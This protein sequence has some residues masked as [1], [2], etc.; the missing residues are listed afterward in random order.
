MS[1]RLLAIGSPGGLF[2]A[3]LD[4]LRPREYRAVSL[5]SCLFTDGKPVFPG[6]LA[7]AL[8]C[9]ANMPDET[10]ESLPDQTDD[11][12]EI[13]H[14]RIDAILLRTANGI[15]FHCFRE[16]GELD[17]Y[18]PALSDFLRKI[19]IRCIIGS[20]KETIFL[21]SLLI[22]KPYQTVDYRL[23]LLA[24]L[25]DP[26]LETLPEVLRFARSRGIDAEALLPLQEGYEKEEVLPP[27]DAFDRKACQEGLIRTLEKQYVN[28]IGD[29]DKPVAKAGT[30][31]RGYLWDQLGGVYTVPEWRQRG[32]AT[33]L[34]AKTSREL[35]AEGRK[36]VLFVKTRNL[37]ACRAYEKVGFKPDILFRI[38]YF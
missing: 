16:D 6:K 34:V 1:S 21:E 25:P 26:A 13:N 15:L 22:E 30:N 7:G 20:G 31:A 17:D 18:R 24:T 11:F 36:I 4:F 14:P 23:M 37:A 8:V 32:L 2:D 35:M 29:G 19:T 27:G 9:L 3:C 33:A 10:N 28:M 12:S 5:A 38:S